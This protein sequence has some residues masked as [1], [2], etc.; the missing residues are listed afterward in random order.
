M[1]L[2]GGII[3]LFLV[4][5][6]RG[7]HLVAAGRNITAQQQSPVQERGESIVIEIIAKQESGKYLSFRNSDRL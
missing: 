3:G 4:G 6:F 5:L 7:A 1:E 2:A